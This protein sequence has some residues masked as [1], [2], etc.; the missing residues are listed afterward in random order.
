MSV[1]HVRELCKNGLI[2][3]DAVWAAEC[4]GCPTNHVLDGDVDIW[5]GGVVW[6]TEKQGESLFIAASPHP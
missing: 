2:D 5:G 6:P 3:L 1:D 4:M